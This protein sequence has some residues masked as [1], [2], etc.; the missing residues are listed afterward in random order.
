MKE[1]IIE[2]IKGPYHPVGNVNYVWIL[3][4]ATITCVDFI[5]QPFLLCF[6]DLNYISENDAKAKKMFIT[7]ITVTNTLSVFFMFDPVY[8]F[9]LSYVNEDNNIVVSRTQIR[10][11]YFVF[12][13]FWCDLLLSFPFWLLTSLNILGPET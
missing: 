7:M 12:K 5:I 10:K 13:N 4:Y 9:N 11:H 1:R 2:T 3:I 8:K 6:Y